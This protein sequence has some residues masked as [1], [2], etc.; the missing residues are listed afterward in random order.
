MIAIVVLWPCG[1]RGDRREDSMVHLS[2]EAADELADATMAM[3]VRRLGRRPTL[4][5]IRETTAAIGA[6]A[7]QGLFGVVWGCLGKRRSDFFGCADRG[8]TTLDLL[9]LADEMYTRLAGETWAKLTFE[10]KQDAMATGLRSM[11]ARFEGRELQASTTNAEF[12]EIEGV[13]YRRLEQRS[14]A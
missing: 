4:A 6:V 9:D 12:I 14:S 7:H 10:Q 2:D 13:T 1:R 8:R 5:E 3:L 11:G